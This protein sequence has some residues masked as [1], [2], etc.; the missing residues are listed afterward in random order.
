MATVRWT[1]Q[2]RRGRLRS[3]H[4]LVDEAGADVARVRRD[5]R[6][7]AT[8]AGTAEDPEG[9]AW[10]VVGT[11]G[12]LLITRDGD[13]RATVQDGVL[14]A[15]GRTFGWRVAED[16]SGTARVT[17]ATGSPS[18]LLRIDPAPG[19]DAGALMTVAFDDTLPAAF[20]VV[21]AATF[22]LLEA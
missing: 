3:Q 8:R 5:G 2:E 19:D 20:G 22:R 15:E 1:L 16:G 13:H 12:D 21:L 4:V 17:S 6:V 18:V 11:P 9:R 10:R 7:V 14:E